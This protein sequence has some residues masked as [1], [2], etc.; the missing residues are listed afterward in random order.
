MSTEADLDAARFGYG[1]SDHDDGVYVHIAAGLWTPRY[2]RGHPDSLWPE[3]RVS[4]WITSAWA[5]CGRGLTWK[6]GPPGWAGPRAC[7]S[8]LRTPARQARIRPAEDVPAPPPVST[9][10]ERTTP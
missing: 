6:W 5:R 10:R 7:G 2:W 8:C 3:D 9:L 1:V 4:L